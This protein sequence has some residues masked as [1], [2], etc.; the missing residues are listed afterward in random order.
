MCLLVLA[1]ALFLRLRALDTTGLW[2]D[3]SFLL[4]TAMRWVNGGPMPLAANKLSAGF[5]SPPMIEYLYAAALWA[6]PDVLSVAL[7][8]A[9]SGLLAVV[10]AGWAT[11]KAFG[12]R[13]ALWTM[14]LFA[15]NPWSVYYSQ[16][17]WNPTMVP[18]FA[19]L[20]FACLLLYFA[21]EQRPAYLVLAFV[22]AA[23]LTQVHPAAATQLLV[24]GVACV[25]FWRKLR[26]WPL[27][28]G[29]ALFGA[30]YAPFL[31]FEATAGW[32]DVQAVLDLARQPAPFSLASWLVSL[33][34]I[35]AHGLLSTVKGVLHFDR[36]AVALLA[37]SL[38]YAG[39]KGAH[40]FF[41][42]RH[43]AEAERKAIAISILLLWFVV[44][45]VFYLRSSHYLQ[46]YY[47]IG[48]V[49]AHF[50]LVGVCLAGAQRGLEHL[51]RRARQGKARRA[52]RLA[53]WAVLPL[54]LLT[55]V[56]WQCA[57]NVHFQDVRRQNKFGD[58]VQIRHIRAAVQAVQRLLAER[59]ECGIVA[60]SEGHRVE[61]SELS[62]LREFTAPERI[63][64]TDGRLAVP[65]PA[66]CGIYLDALP[67]S[68][69]S[70]WVAATATPLAEA[71]PAPD[72][73]WRF[74]ALSAARPDP[75]P[76]RLATWQNGVALTRYERG[77]V[78]P[79]AALSLTLEWVVEAPPPRKV[80][81]VGTYLLTVDNQV[82]AQSDGPGFDS[83]QWRVGDR[84]I[85]WFDIAVPPDLPPGDYQIAVA[86]Y[87][88]PW[89][90]RVDLTSGGNTAF[91]ERV[92]VP[93]P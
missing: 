65:L 47:M 73:T 77:G 9:I 71:I 62:L 34:V 86:F 24:M 29:V 51:A 15:V 42:R 19:A 53:A 79:G 40:A 70:R 35:R 72:A 85:A 32:M 45:V 89:L 11:Y 61:L 43:H 5:M 64:L 74:Y 58:A 69:A 63:L 78:V 60:I 27:L 88:W 66:T 67:G 92:A 90:E 21:V 80:Y 4:N 16:L 49:P 46:L 59:P 22:W 93:S 55:L 2:G 87:S 6:W 56:I 33:D 12:R 7:L 54:P 83:I 1:L 17:I 30:L 20:T 8:T 82:V 25:L 10:V 68:R 31:V 57:F 50:V 41:R 38:A 48:Q 18:L 76:A 13:A 26:L 3:Q 81:H 23:C 91:L 44:P 52:V 36:L 39:G 84:F 75:V 14:L 28:L 37:L